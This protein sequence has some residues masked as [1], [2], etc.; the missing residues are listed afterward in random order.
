MMITSAL[1]NSWAFLAVL[2]AFA[3]ILIA[4][5]V[6]MASKFFGS[7]QLENQAKGE[8]VFAAST[9][10]LV[11]FVMGVLAVADSIAKEYLNQVFFNG[12]I[13]PS[14]ID[15]SSIADFVIFSL[16]SSKDCSVEI[17]NKLYIMDIYVQAVLSIVMEVGMSELATGFFMNVF[18]ERIT[19]FTSILTFY[20]IIYYVIF[21]ILMFLKYFGMYFF[22]LGV[23]LRAFPPTRGA[24]AFIMALCI[25]L[26]FIFPLSYILMSQMFLQYYGSLGFETLNAGDFSSFIFGATASSSCAMDSLKEFDLVLPESTAGAFDITRTVFENSLYVQANENIFTQLLDSITAFSDMI[27]MQ[28]CLLPFLALTIT[29]SFVLSSSALFG[30][31]IPEVGRGLIK[32]I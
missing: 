16:Q 3:S 29:L 18:S 27:V 9:L 6:Y 5:I 24:G 19:N 25:G 1:Q 20:I 2:A 14:V 13:P 30:A 28:L 12:T 22:V 11:L 26:Y 21:D 17:L 8:I 4:I 32:L 10:V 23:V 7:G 15:K 31:T